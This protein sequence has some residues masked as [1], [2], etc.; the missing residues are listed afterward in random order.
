M[1]VASSI[2]SGWG[3]IKT[4][5]CMCLSGNAK[6]NPL[7]NYWLQLPKITFSHDFLPILNT[8]YQ[9]FMVCTWC[10]HIFFEYPLH[11]DQPDIMTATFMYVKILHITTPESSQSVT[12][13]IV[14]CLGGLI[15]YTYTWAH[16]ITLLISLWTSP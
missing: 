15:M 4:D 10:F 16:V 7:I 14:R 9:K 5:L 2:F 13:L 12:R 6:S 3:I 11:T 8:I 1:A